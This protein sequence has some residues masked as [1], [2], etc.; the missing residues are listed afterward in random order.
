MLN[1]CVGPSM[2]PTFIGKQELCLSTKITATTALAR[3]DIVTLQLE[4][5]SNSFVKRIIGLPGEQ[6]MIKNNQ[7]YINGV[8]LEETYLPEDYHY[9]SYHNTILQTRPLGDDE[10]F[11]LGDNREISIDSKDFGPVSRQAMRTK[12][13]AILFSL[14]LHKIGMLHT[15]TY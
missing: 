9:Q 12:F 8:R 7:I 15:L 3:G 5:T 2:H 6:V 4:D 13:Q 1:L 14:D 10:Y 11:L